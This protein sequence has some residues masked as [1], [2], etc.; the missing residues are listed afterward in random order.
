MPMFDYKCKNCDQLFEELVSSSTVSDS[1]ITCPHCRARRAKRQLSAP[2]VS[3]KASF[4]PAC[5]KR[6]CSTP[7]S[8]GF[9]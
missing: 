7:A 2:T 5:E 3:V 9:G 4:E 1:E 6:G 8:S